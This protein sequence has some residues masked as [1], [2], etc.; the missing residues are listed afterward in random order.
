MNCVWH[1]LFFVQEYLCLEI[2]TY[3]IL[4]KL[5]IHSFGFIDM[6]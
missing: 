6:A 1:K 4:A 2:I 5:K 3:L